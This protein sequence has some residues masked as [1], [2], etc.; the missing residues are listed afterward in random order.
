MIKIEKGRCLIKGD[1][2][3]IFTD[4]CGFII[5]LVENKELQELLTD[6]VKE[7]EKLIKEGLY[8]PH[9]TGNKSEK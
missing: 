2:A 6:A 3:D 5:A 7:V 4:M 8:V 1:G 9:N